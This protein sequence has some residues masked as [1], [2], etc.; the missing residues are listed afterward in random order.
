MPSKAEVRPECMACQEMVMCHGRFQ[1]GTH[2]AV[3]ARC[4]SGTSVKQPLI[5]NIL[6]PLS[7]VK[8]NVS[9]MFLD[10]HFCCFSFCFLIFFPVVFGFPFFMWTS[11]FFCHYLI[12]FSVDFGFHFFHLLYHVVEHFTVLKFAVSVFTFM[13]SN[14]FIFHR[15]CLFLFPVHCVTVHCVPVLMS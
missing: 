11:V 8:P 13:L 12:F 4:D 14:M 7:E 6:Q 3:E 10:F 5:M 2:C 1:A 9:S 15:V